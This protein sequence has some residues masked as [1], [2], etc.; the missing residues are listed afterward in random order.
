MARRGV[1]WPVSAGRLGMGLFGVSDR[2]G[3]TWLGPARL[4]STAW[5][6]AVLGWPGSFCHLG[7]EWP[8]RARDVTSVG[9]GLAQYGLSAWTGRTRAGETRSREDCRLGLVEVGTARRCGPDWLERERRGP[10]KWPGA[11]GPEAAR[12]VSLVRFGLAR[13][14]RECR[15]GR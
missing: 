13:P 9:L 15:T 5:H 10:S 8:E 14:G 1:V 7:A 12:F 6:G 4:V 2:T 11:V 3:T